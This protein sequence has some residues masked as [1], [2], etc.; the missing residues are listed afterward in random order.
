MLKSSY[1]EVP[2]RITTNKKNLLTKVGS[3]FQ[4]LDESDRG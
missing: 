3:F 1:L 4:P 2:R